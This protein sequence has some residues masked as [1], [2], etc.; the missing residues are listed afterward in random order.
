MNV[1]RVVSL[2]ILRSR[3]YVLLQRRPQG[4]T[5]PGLWQFPGG[6]V[7]FGEH[8]WDAL[9]RELAEELGARVRKGRLFGVYSHLYDLGGSRVHYILVA[10][11]VRVSRSSV[12]AREDLRWVALKDLGQWPIVPGS[13]PIVADLLRGP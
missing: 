7:E 5:L 12:R 11:E 1:P 3:G 13:G 2:A 9:R 4:G 6:K 8:P 10:Y